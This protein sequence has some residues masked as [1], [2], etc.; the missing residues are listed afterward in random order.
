MLGK[1]NPRRTHVL[2][3][4]QRRKFTKKKKTTTTKIKFLVK[5]LRHNSFFENYLYVRINIAIITNFAF[6]YETSVREMIERQA[7]Y[8]IFEK[9]AKTTTILAIIIRG[10]ICVYVVKTRQRGTYNST[11]RQNDNRNTLKFYVYAN[12]R[13]YYRNCRFEHFF[14][15]FCEF[16]INFRS[17]YKNITFFV[18]KY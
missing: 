12:N 5:R 10:T 14:D 18:C 8:D 11:I 1:N 4:R 6:A 9:E 15:V 2:S 16:P 3:T 13:T 17:D 7:V